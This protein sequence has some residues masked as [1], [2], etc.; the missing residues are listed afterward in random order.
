MRTIRWGIIGVGSVTEV[1]SGPGFQQARNSAL[2]AV[3]RR[4]GDLARDY[5]RR[6]GVAKWY[7]DADALINDP[8]VDAVYIATPPDS[9]MLYTLKV[10][11][12]G[13]PVYVEKPM[14]R[15]YAECQ[16]ML[17]A[18]QAA[19][20]PLFVAHYRRGL[21]RFH[22]VKALLEAEKIGAVRFVRVTL[23]QK[24]RPTHRQADNL[25]WRVIPEIAGG[26]IFLDLA[27]HTLDI[28]DFLL[29]PIRSAQGFA[30]NQAGLY[31]AEDTVSGQ[32]T[33]ESG[34]HGVGVWCFDTYSDVDEV[35][36]VGTHGK[37]TFATFG[38]DPLLLTTADGLTEF[39]IENP[40]H[41]QQPLIQSIVDA[42]NGEGSC[43]SDGV[44]AARTSWVMDR[45]LESCG[46]TF[47]V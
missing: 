21:P 23:Y 28:L 6:H 4:N 3:M 7:D 33:F 35:E 31:P 22:K 10:A 47:G 11:Q 19:G 1:K 8:D 26:G 14:A 43:L 13:K 18:C 20:V 40:P 39:V 32:F 2:V 25:P 42:L 12:A 44:T 9:H 46:Y 16:A 36:I 38:A 24:A 29:G 45:L 15:S 30:S 34:V 17:A 37:L 41:I 27:P 5:A